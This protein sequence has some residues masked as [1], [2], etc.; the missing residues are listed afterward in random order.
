M[1]G[2]VMAG[3][4]GQRLRPLTC[5][6]PKPMAPFLGKPVM[7]HALLR[8]QEAGIQRVGA[9][10]SYRAE[11]IQRYFG[12][13]LRYFVEDEPQGTAGSL[14]AAR[15]FLD[16]SFVVVSGDALT[17]IQLADAIRFHQERGALATLVLKKVENP[18]EYGVVLTDERG[19]VRRFLEK[20]G[21]S[22]VFSDQVNT[23][24]YILEPELLSLLPK[25]G[26]YD[27]GKQ[28]FPAMVEKG[29]PLYGYVAKGYWC[30]IG[31]SA[32]YLRAHMD[33][34]AGRIRGFEPK[35]EEGA[36]VEGGAQLQGP[37]WI[38]KGSRVCEGARL[39]PF[40]VVG[41]DCCVRPSASVRASVLWDGVL[42]GERA[43]LRGALAL[44]GAQVLRG[45]QMYE[46]SVLGSGAVLGEGASLADGAMVWPG[47]RVDAGDRLRGS[48]VRGRAPLRWDSRGVYADSAT[49]PGP[50]RFCALG[51]VLGRACGKEGFALAH[52]GSGAAQMG[53]FALCAG[54]AAAGCQAL[55]A[56]EA[57]P[58][59]LACAQDE[60]GAGGAAYLCLRGGRLRVDL[61][62]RQGLEH[63]VAERRAL[64]AALEREEAPGLALEQL[65]FPVELQGVSALRLMQLVLLAD[66]AGQAGEL[67]LEAAKG[68]AAAEAEALFRP[69]GAIR[70]R[71]RE[72]LEG[73]ELWDEKGRAVSEAVYPLLCA[74]VAHCFAPG[75][76]VMGAWQDSDALEEMAASLGV[77]CLRCGPSRRE[78]MELT[79]DHPLYRT[80]FFD[81]IGALTLLLEALK[82]WDLPLWQLVDRLPKRYRLEKRLPC[83]NSRKGRV[84]Q[85]VAQALAPRSPLLEHGVRLSL[86]ER[87]AA[88]L[89]PEEDSESFYL[90]SESPDAEFA[91]ELFDEMEALL[92]RSLAQEEAGENK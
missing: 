13:R 53:L 12:D 35:V 24:I 20:P 25:E 26:P 33:A 78:R 30:D 46:G 48:L 74:A 40:A 84:L 54:L 89:Y 87:G 1:K 61:Y 82:K 19:R 72:D 43:E 36:L 63:S 39:G 65:P 7:E 79:R 50:E 42:V 69:G 21:W 45:G 10:L 70:A 29:L 62:D 75:A 31:D 83:R 4:G 11:Q 64:Q 22:Q 51:R 14:R 6:L 57:S 60:Y 3:G 38:G 41:R 44:D 55:L 17:D 28:L 59:A 91:R 34:L 67:N 52:D 90:R 88:F 47:K 49:L 66:L 85:R 23:G 73:V 68:P 81:G 18:L 77:R 16:E 92:A 71:L 15:D 58:Q 27:F 80:L 9:T 8:L 76:P 56:G 2:I 86:G 32:Q 37:V 5:L